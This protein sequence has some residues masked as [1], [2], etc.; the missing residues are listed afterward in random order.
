MW[1]NRR[2]STHNYVFTSGTRDT[3]GAP[4]DLPK[5]RDIVNLSPQNTDYFLNIK[6]AY[7]HGPEHRAAQDPSQAKAD[8]SNPELVHTD[9][10]HTN[11][12]EQI[13][14][15]DLPQG[16]AIDKELEAILIQT[17]PT[18]TDGLGHQVVQ[19]TLQGQA[20][21]TKPLIDRPARQ[22]LSPGVQSPLPGEEMHS[23]SEFSL[24]SLTPRLTSTRNH[25]IPTMM[26]LDDLRISLYAATTLCED[27]LNRFSIS[28]SMDQEEYND[29]KN[30]LKLATDTYP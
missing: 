17:Q 1:L 26:E 23:L 27:I 20:D 11:S 8:D 30:D 6:P 18:L 13:A 3:A 15:Q 29:C 16:G 22:E 25:Q 24:A 7:T 10:A 2:D 12:L 28:S 21:K 5:S 19:D 9:P 14:A 4:L